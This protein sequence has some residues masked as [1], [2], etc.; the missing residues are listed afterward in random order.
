[1]IH[2]M[3]HRLFVKQRPQFTVRFVL[4]CYHIVAFELTGLLVSDVFVYGLIEKLFGDRFFMYKQEGILDLT[5][6]NLYE[7]S[8]FEEKTKVDVKDF[9]KLKMVAEMNDQV[10]RDIA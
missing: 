9:E 7:S 3:H 6:I 10:R 8:V 5:H 4:D 1:M 2:M